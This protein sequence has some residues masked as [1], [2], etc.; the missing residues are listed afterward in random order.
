MPGALPAGLRLLV[1]LGR[2][3]RA[4]LAVTVDLG[5]GNR[6]VVAGC[7]L[8]HGGTPFVLRG[9]TSPFSPPLLWTRAGRDSMPW[10]QGRTPLQGPANGDNGAARGLTPAF[11]GRRRRAMIAVHSGRQGASSG[12][13]GLLKR[14]GPQ[15]TCALTWGPAV[16]RVGLEPTTN[17][18]KVLARACRAVMSGAAP[19]ETRRSGEGGLT[20]GPS[21]STRCQH[22]RS[23][24]A[25]ASVTR[26]AAAHFRN[27]DAPS[28]RQ[29]SATRVS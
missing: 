4:H 14:Q 25:H 23:R 10:E 20:P 12:A 21:G 19:S 26:W 27:D 15:V 24:I 6:L 13:L 22:V 29:S 8:D 28:P 16:G 9:R 5:V 2:A 1:P 3:D 11:V 18:L 17:G 7:A